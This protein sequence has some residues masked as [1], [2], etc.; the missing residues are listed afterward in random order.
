M[1]WQGRNNRN[2]MPNWVAANT[3]ICFGN[4]T[5]FQSCK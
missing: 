2:G 5:R 1:A 4:E 3:V